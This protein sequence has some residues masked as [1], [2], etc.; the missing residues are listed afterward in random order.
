M[1]RSEHIFSNPRL[2]CLCTDWAAKADWNSGG[3]A[4]KR[5][6]KAVKSP[7]SPQDA[8]ILYLQSRVT[9][10]QLGQQG[11]EERAGEENVEVLKVRRH[12]GC[13][14][15]FGSIQINCIKSA[16]LLRTLV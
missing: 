2:V 7:I 9:L 4:P 6:G 1:Y 15:S 3:A 14:C 11:T 5:I 13:H 12:R 10:P 8:Y 16:V